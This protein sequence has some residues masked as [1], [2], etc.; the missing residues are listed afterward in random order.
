[1]LSNSGHDEY[2]L[3]SGGQAGDQSGNEWSIIPWYQYPW[4]GGWQYVLH[5]PDGSVRALIAK[6]AT[7]AANNDCI[8][9]DQAQRYT[10]WQ[11]LQL[12]GYRPANIKTPCEADCSAGVAAI[13]KAVGYLVGNEK[14][15]AVSI[16][17]YTGNLLPVLTQAGFTALNASK[18]LTS[19]A[20]LFAGD[21]LLNTEYHTCICITNGSQAEPVTDTGYKFKTATV[22]LGSQGLNVW[23]FQAI[24]KARGF[25]D[26]DLDGSYGQKTKKA[27]IRL[28]E[29]MR[30]TKAYANDETWFKL[31]NLEK[32]DGYWIAKQI[33]ANS[34]ASDS[35]TLCQ[36]FLQA[37]GY[38][39]GGA[40]DGT[41]KTLT[42]VAVEAFQ[43]DHDLNVDG[44]CGPATWKKL[45]NR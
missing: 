7:E 21:I 29:K 14:L 9:Y 25:Y 45:L 34:T 15:K 39:K 42:R 33:Q 13:V 17:A 18:Y 20:Y 30:L 35:I 32:K 27:A 12:A 6:L 24:L 41:F 44:I 19:D 23:R 31:L 16:Y 1:M 38:Y 10:F 2:G 40:L 4:G 43:R 22:R 37:H 36:E 11:A 28:K 3:Y 26:G 5:H 8:G